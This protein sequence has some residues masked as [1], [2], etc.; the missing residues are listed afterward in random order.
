MKK[1]PKVLVVGGGPSGSA[2]A[3]TVASAGGDVTLIEGKN[4]P[5][6]RPGET[7][8]PGVEPLFRQLGV[9]GA[10]EAA[11]FLRHVGNRVQWGDEPE[12]QSFGSDE[13][14]RWTGY[15][16]DRGKLDSI[17]L[18][19]ARGCGVRVLQPCRA[20]VPLTDGDRVTGVET[21]R[22]E[23]RTDWILDATGLGHWLVRH[24]GVPWDRRSPRLMVRYGYVSMFGQD[25]DR[26]QNPCMRKDDGG[27][28]WI[29]KVS[30][31]RLAWARMRRAGTCDRDGWVPSALGSYLPVGCGGAADVTWRI[32]Q[33]LAGSG[34]FL[35]GDSGAVLDPASSHGVLK[36]VMSGIMAG[37]LITSTGQ[38]K[39]QTGDASGIFTDW[40]REWFDRDVGEL[41]K[42]YGAW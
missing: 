9:A 28:T 11:G 34:W 23:I 1:K 36:A 35:L 12:F 5:R 31:D 25:G 3:I 38:G 19:R 14:G 32:S 4:F 26:Y 21:D 42:L 41:Q 18:T 39:I 8:H 24:L 16:A 40:S 29:A 7:L 10:V 33:K 6:H 13:Q 20:G 15:Q 27:W 22:G 30:A 37:D 2:A 17:L